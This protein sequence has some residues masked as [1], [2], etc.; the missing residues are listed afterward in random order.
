MLESELD[1]SGTISN[2]YIHYDTGNKWL[3]LPRSTKSPPACFRD[4]ALAVCNSLEACENPDYRSTTFETVRH[5]AAAGEGITL[6]PKLAYGYNDGLVY[7]PFGEPSPSREIGLVWRKGN[8]RHRFLGKAVAMI[9]K[10]TRGCG[11]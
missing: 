4:Q 9:E 11:N 1:L 5:L 7:V 3:C 6:L 8:K 10:A 2:Q